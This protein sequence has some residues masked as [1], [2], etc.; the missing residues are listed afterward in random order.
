MA[1]ACYMADGINVQRAFDAPARSSLRAWYKAATK[2]IPDA[3]QFT[4]EIE[5]GAHVSF[6][7]IIFSGKGWNLIIAR[8]RTLK[9]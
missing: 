1:V 7:A 2:M 5:A 8:R 4:P 9:A 6:E 3:P